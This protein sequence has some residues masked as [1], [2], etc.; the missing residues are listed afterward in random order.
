[1]RHAGDVGHPHASAVAS[2]P[3]LLDAPA[4][5]RHRREVAAPPAHVTK[6]AR[7]IREQSGVTRRPRALRPRGCRGCRSGGSRC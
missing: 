4:H 7:A 5:G 6:V 1:L 3:K 2:D